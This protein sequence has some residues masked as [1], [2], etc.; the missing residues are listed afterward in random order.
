M[1]YSDNHD[2][3][4]SFGV[5]SIKEF[6]SIETLDNISSIFSLSGTDPFHRLVLTPSIDSFAHFS[7][8]FNVLIRICSMKPCIT[9]YCMQ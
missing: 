7:A 6:H 3:S 5:E 2:K 8:L 1:Y 9:Y 4:Q